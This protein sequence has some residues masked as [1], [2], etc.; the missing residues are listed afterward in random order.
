[1]YFRKNGVPVNGNV[2][3]NFSF[4][5]ENFKDKKTWMYLGIFVLVILLLVFLYMK[6]KQRV[7]ETPRFGLKFL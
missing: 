2:V 4:G 3:E 5:K 6:Y 1:M 7:K